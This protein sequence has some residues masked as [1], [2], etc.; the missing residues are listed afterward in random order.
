[1]EHQR[2]QKKIN[3]TY[4]KAET[5]ERLKHENN[6]KYMRQM[7]EQEVKEAQRNQAKNGETFADMRAK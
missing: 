2:A 4:S 7:K 5:L 3:E 1:M 6:Q